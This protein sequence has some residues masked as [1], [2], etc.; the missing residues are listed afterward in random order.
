M[1]LIGI[2][3]GIYMKLSFQSHRGRYLWAR[4]I[5]CDKECGE[6]DNFKICIRIK[7]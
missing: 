4:Y 2:K 5:K 7:L 3:L 1:K 6:T